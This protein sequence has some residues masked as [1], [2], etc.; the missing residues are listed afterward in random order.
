MESIPG[1]HTIVNMSINGDKFHQMLFK[2][3]HPHIS[4]Y[5]LSDMDATNLETLLHPEV[6]PRHVI[7]LPMCKLLPTAVPN[8]VSLEGHHLDG[9]I[10]FK[11]TLSNELSKF[12][13]FAEKSKA[14][15]SMLNTAYQNVRYVSAGG[16]IQEIETADGANPSFYGVGLC[17]DI[18]KNGSSL[19]VREIVPGSPAAACGLISV[20]DHLI[21]IDGLSAKHSCPTLE[22]VVKLIR[23]IEGTKVKLQFRKSSGP[24]AK[25]IYDVTLIRGPNVTKLESVEEE[26]SSV[27]DS[28]HHISVDTVTEPTKEHLTSQNFQNAAAAVEQ[29]KAPLHH[30][31][32]NATEDYV[33]NLPD[34]DSLQHSGGLNNVRTRD[35]HSSAD[36]FSNR[37]SRTASKMSSRSQSPFDDRTSQSSA[38]LP[39]PSL[40]H[41]RQIA[42]EEINRQIFEDGI[43]FSQDPPKLSESDQKVS[44]Y[45]QTHRSATVHHSSQND[46]NRPIHQV[47]ATNMGI[48]LMSTHDD[49]YQVHSIASNAPASAHHVCIGDLLWA[50]DREP[51]A[52]K[53]K[54]EICRILSRPS[55]L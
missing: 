28:E 5:K 54:E 46:V 50:I 38:R 52:S 30:E 40:F 55:A 43:S 42:R 9:T 33:S 35:L 32:D 41:M 27:D 21:K 29:E 3:N 53:S 51:V 19:T 8:A 16:N 10:T 39:A 26:L 24:K 25:S 45:L 37:G 34:D 17:I 12:F 15:H 47:F 36:D 2:F 48:T 6:E 4:L 22:D 14:I 1:W 44:R 20:H 23:G 11:F 18:S 31:S 7:F 49:R 13:D